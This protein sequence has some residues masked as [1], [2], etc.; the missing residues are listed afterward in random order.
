MQQSARI[1]DSSE[2]AH[3]ETLMRLV[4]C[5]RQLEAEHGVRRRRLVRSIVII[6]VLA[7]AF[8][9]A[10][11]LSMGWSARDWAVLV[12][13]AGVVLAIV[14]AVRAQKAWSDRVI[15]ALMPEI[16]RAWGELHYAR[17]APRSDFVD[18]FVTLH[19]V[20]A[21]NQRKLEHYFSG[22][23]GDRRFEMLHADLSRSSGRRHGSRNS[24]SV[25]IFHGLLIRVQLL[26]P[27]PLPILILP[28][29]RLTGKIRD[30][31]PVPLESPAFADHFAVH[32]PGD[33]PDGPQLAR[34]FL[35]QSRQDALLAINRS[36]GRLI[37][38]RTA[39]RVGLIGD[40]GY[41]SLSRW[42]E[43]GQV[44]KLR[45]ERPRPFLAVPWLLR[46]SMMLDSCVRDMLEDAG[47]VFRIIDQLPDT[48][49]T[50][51]PVA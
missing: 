47:V 32:V 7:L 25:A 24:T 26:R 34:S 18:P 48:P 41:L 29:S 35:D 45:F 42:A 12:M 40:S 17:A 39:L 9:L 49:Q 23:L 36:E 44:G 50:P 4:P 13:I 22:R 33:R 5:F 37:D 2:E 30:M 14:W 27:A 43:G 10:M 6:L 46:R 38:G 31:A 8:A 28:S 21:H 11:L 20:G 1:I 16:C 15:D 3:A 19:A 51:K